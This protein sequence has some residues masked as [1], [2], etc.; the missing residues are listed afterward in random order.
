PNNALA[1]YNKA[2]VHTMSGEC[3]DIPA[4]SNQALSLSP[5]DPLQY[6]FLAVR[7]LGHLANG[8]HEPAR[9]W[10]EQAANAPLAH[11]L[12]DFIATVC[13][14]QAGDIAQAEFRRDRVLARNPEFKRSDYFRSMPTQDPRNIAA[15]DEAFRN[16][17]LSMD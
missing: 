14:Y 10:A 15:V 11:H 4:L 9:H 7:A 2:L 13:N 16:L 5:I 8:E 12:I 3:D 17:G 1:Y 6:A